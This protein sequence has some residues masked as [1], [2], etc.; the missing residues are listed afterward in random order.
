[1]TNL[2]IALDRKIEAFKRANDIRLDPRINREQIWRLGFYRWLRLEGEFVD[3][4]G[5]INV[6]MEKIDAL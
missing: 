6:F 1:M 2:P 5:S 4:D 3:D